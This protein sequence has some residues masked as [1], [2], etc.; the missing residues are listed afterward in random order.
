MYYLKI[1]TNEDT[2]KSDE[3]LYYCR[4]CG[5]EENNLT[6]ENICVSTFENNQNNDKYD[7]HIN[8]YTKLD[9]TLPRI[10]TIKCP[11]SNCITNNETDKKR[12]IIYVRYNDTDM[13]Y[14]YMCS[15][16]NTIWKTTINN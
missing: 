5:N 8:E 16:C 1:K 7:S 12:E 15:D 3:L 13:K 10:N 4:N 9:P 2:D 6:T 14:V 11:N